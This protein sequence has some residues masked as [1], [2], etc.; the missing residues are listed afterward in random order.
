M[1]DILYTKYGENLLEN[2]EKNPDYE[3][4]PEYPRP[5]LKREGYWLNLNGYWDYAIE[6]SDGSFDPVLNIPI[7]SE[8]IKK[9][10]SAYKKFSSQ[11]KILVPFS[12]ETALSGVNRSVKPDEVLWYRRKFSVKSLENKGRYILQFGA[13]DQ[14][15]SVFI[16][17]EYVGSHRDGYLPFSFDISSRINKSRDEQELVVAVID[18]QDKGQLPF[19]KQSTNP[20]MIWYRPSSGIWQSVWLESV[21]ATYLKNVKTTPS[22]AGSSVNIEIELDYV[23]SPEIN[24]AEDIYATVEFFAKGE[25]QGKQNLNLRGKTN[26]ILKDRFAWSPDNPFL[27]DWTINI[28]K[29]SDNNSAKNDELLI[30]SVSGYF[31]LRD[32]SIGKDKYGYPCIL[33][34]GEVL[35]HIGVLDQGYWSDG[36]YTPASDEAFI[37]DILFVKSL[38]YNMIRKHIKIEPQ[39]WY[40]HCDRLGILVWQDMVNG[41]SDY[42]RFFVNISPFIGLNMKDT[43]GK[44]LGRS[45][46]KRKGICKKDRITIAEKG[47][48]AHLEIMKEAVDVLYNHPS[49]VCWVPFN[50]GWGQFNALEV[51]KEFRS[52]DQSRLIDHASGWHD[53]NGPDFESRHKYF[54]KFRDKAKQNGRPF[55]LSEY[56]GYTFTVPDHTLDMAQFGYGTYKSQTEYNEAVIRL[57]EEQITQDKHLA[58]TVYTQLSDVEGESNGLITYDRKYDK[59]SIPQNRN[60]FIKINRDLQKE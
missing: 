33:L 17:G 15:C 24:F 13:V 21:P 42:I 19:G 27:Y 7:F 8:D 45:G 10:V 36:L 11:G 20:K 32:V 4:F 48:L 44:L 14:T 26:Y 18:P 47:K 37:D 38:G 1:N 3:I 53:Q 60:R 5:Q 52:W 16:N 49:I 40:Y 57:H 54:L 35:R 34:N 59:W 31:G 56:G 41:G 9:P 46:P 6:K 23:K 2:I 30:D 55:A 58:A 43:T 39:R 29:N 12:P 25:S 50:E 51:A 22:F 28:Y